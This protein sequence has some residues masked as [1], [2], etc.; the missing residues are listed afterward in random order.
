[1]LVD[2]VDDALPV[3]VLAACKQR[4]P[5]QSHRGPLP[6]LVAVQVLGDDRVDKQVVLLSFCEKVRLGLNKLHLLCL[7]LLV[8]VDNPNVVC[9]RMLDHLR[10]LI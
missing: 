4:L 1:M 9:E 3:V 7:E 10:V 8:R 2:S 6:L 5:L